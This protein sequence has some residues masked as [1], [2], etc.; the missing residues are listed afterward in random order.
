MAKVNMP[1]RSA[2]PPSST[3]KK[4]PE[5]KKVEKV[6]TGEVTTR[7]KSLGK[8]FSE[9]FLG[10]DINNVRSYIFFDVIIPAVKD[11]I[12]NVVS[13][14]IEMLLFGEPRRTGSKSNGSY[15]SYSNYYS[16]KEERR[17][18][19]SSRG[20]AHDFR[21]IILQTRGEAEEV[22]S[23]LVD[24]VYDYGSAS[25]ADM[26]DLVGITGNFTDNKYGWTDLSGCR[27]NRARGGGYIIDLPKV[28][29][30]D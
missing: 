1:E 28:E 23:N 9:T 29:R 10:D 18:T 27:V 3:T 8:K 17:S 4:K 26:Y 13:N 14:G 16:K 22:L 20:T 24:I 19:P 2:F 7:K 5:E 21:D 11:T 15:T 25:V 6:I 30:L 12:S